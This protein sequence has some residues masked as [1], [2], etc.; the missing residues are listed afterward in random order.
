MTII[1]FSR[2]QEWQ[3]VRRVNME[4]KSIGKI[5][6]GFLEGIK[7]YAITREPSGQSVRDFGMTRR[8]DCII[9]CSQWIYKA[10]L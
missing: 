2:R 4:L 9:F 5:T 10:E 7:L 6:L 3:C 1:K 8:L